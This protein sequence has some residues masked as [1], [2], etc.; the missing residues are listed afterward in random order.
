M[1]TTPYPLDDQEHSA[2]KQV[3]REA[4][5]AN[6]AAFAGLARL[7]ARGSG[8]PQSGLFLIDGPHAWPVA[9]VS[10]VTAPMPRAM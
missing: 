10:G 4:I 5:Q 7:L 8:A 1:T 9:S 3:V 6:E 2:L